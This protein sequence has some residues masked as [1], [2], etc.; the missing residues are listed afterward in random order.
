MAA[1][2]PDGAVK[3]LAESARNA[4]EVC[5][6]NR[7]REEENPLHESPAYKIYFPNRFAAN[8]TGQEN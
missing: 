1:E 7:L 5:F 3:A 4:L 8:S 6:R 2:P